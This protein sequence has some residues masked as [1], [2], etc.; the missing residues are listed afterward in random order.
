MF[1][2]KLCTPLLGGQSET[3]T[4]KL[5]CDHMTLLLNDKH[6]N[7]L[8]FPPTFD[9]QVYASGRLSHTYVSDVK[10]TTEGK[11]K[12]QHSQLQKRQHVWLQK[13]TTRLVNENK[14]GYKND[15]HVWLQKRQ[16]VWLTTTR[17]VTKTTI[18]TYTRKRTLITTISTGSANM[19]CTSD[20]LSPK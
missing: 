15:K 6:T 5:D 16:H 17:L 12:R 9:I 11:F 13:T 14:F 1:P 20:E 2:L 18:E 3:K 19:S 8:M 7:Q 10:F 4:C